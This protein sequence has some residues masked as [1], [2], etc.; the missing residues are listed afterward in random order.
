MEESRRHSSDLQLLNGAEVCMME[1]KRSGCVE[2]G[3]TREVGQ[4]GK[5]GGP[6]RTRELH[7]Q[8]EAEGLVRKGY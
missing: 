2:Q 1:K 3:R 4:M 6:K 7:R 8:K 5:D